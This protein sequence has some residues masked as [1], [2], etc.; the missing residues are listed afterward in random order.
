MNITKVKYKLI[1]FTIPAVDLRVDC[2][3]VVYLDDGVDSTSIVDWKNDMKGETLVSIIYKCQ[4][5]QSIQDLLRYM[6][7]KVTY[8]VEETM[9]IIVNHAYINREKYKA[10]SIAV[11]EMMKILKSFSDLKDTNPDI[12]IISV[13][14]DTMTF[15]ALL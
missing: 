13:D 15:I 1:T 7:S 5:P 11:L 6:K 4:L 12:R 8:D 3:G 14:D 10:K 9:T 2:D